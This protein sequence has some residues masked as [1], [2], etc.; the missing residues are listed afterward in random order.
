MRDFALFLVSFFFSDFEQSLVEI[1]EEFREFLNGD[2]AGGDFPT[3][4]FDLQS[5]SFIVID[6]R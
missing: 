4:E 2:F 3:C 6:V 5:D 1:A